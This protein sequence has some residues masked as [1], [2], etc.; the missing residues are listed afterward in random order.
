PDDLAKF[1]DAHLEPGFVTLETGSGISTVIFLD[2]RV[3]A[4]FVIQPDW[5]EFRALKQ[6]AS[7]HGID[8]SPARMIVAKSQDYL[9]G[10]QLPELDIVLVDGDHSFP[11]P[12]IDWS[13]TA[14][15]LRTGGL[16]IIDD[17][18]ILTGTLLADFM[19]ADPKW[20]EVIRHERFAVYRKIRHPIHDGAWLG[21]PYLESSF[22]VKEVTIGKRRPPLRFRHIASVML[23]GR[24]KQFVR[25]LNAVSFKSR[26]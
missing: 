26:Q 21:Q 20:Q 24:V 19:A 6:F 10:A 9:P 25:A 16:M 5:D 13:Y 15:R 12:F 23:P 8:M 14:E 4:H 3:S 17:I 22:P 1:L 11:V 2:K 7:E 18:H